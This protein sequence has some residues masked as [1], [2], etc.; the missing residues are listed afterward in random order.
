MEFHEDTHVQHA[1]VWTGICA[2]SCACRSGCLLRRPVAHLHTAHTSPMCAEKLF[3]YAGQSFFPYPGPCLNRSK[4]ISVSSSLSYAPGFPV[5]P[6]ALTLPA[7]GTYLESTM[8]VTEP[9]SS[10][11]APKLTWCIVVAT[12]CCLLWWPSD[13]R[14]RP[15][16]WERS[17]CFQR[18]EWANGR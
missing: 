17:P 1:V 18:E 4:L 10:S 6:N 16:I 3:I 8:V 5:N 14:L 2:H 12:V 9:H 11:G 13:D 7:P 15:L